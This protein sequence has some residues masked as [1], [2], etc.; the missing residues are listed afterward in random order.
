MLRQRAGAAC[1]G[2]TTTAWM[3]VW[4]HVSALTLVPEGEASQRKD[5]GLAQLGKGMVNI[6]AGEG[7]YWRL[8]LLCNIKMYVEQNGCTCVA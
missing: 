2:A 4:P 1:E 8:A 5:A 6:Q 7:I 3:S